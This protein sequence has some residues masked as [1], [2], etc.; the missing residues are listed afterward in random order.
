MLR[1]EGE[2]EL[3]TSSA[4]THVPQ[5]SRQSVVIAGAR[6]PVVSFVAKG[7]AADKAGLQLKD[8]LIAINGE[9]V[10]GDKGF[11]DLLDKIPAGG[12]AKVE[13]MRKGK[14]LDL[15]MKPHD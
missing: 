8:G 1:R 15:V 5:S 2:F 9:G 7:S 10:V 13:V 4:N 3:M 12:T 6:T 14:T 11:S